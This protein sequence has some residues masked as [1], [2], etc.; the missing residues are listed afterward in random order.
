MGRLKKHPDFDPDRIMRELMD[1]VSGIYEETGKIQRTAEEI[2]VSHLKVRKILV[3]AGVFENE[4]A[5][6]ISSLY[7]S[8]KS[9]LEIQEITV[10]GRSAVNAYL[11]YV[12][13]PYNTSELSANAERIRVF[14][15]RKACV[16]R[17]Q[18]DMTEDAL[19]K[20][21]VV[22]QNYRFSTM[23]GLPFSYTL[24]VGRNGQLNKE[25]LVSRRKESKTLAWSS[26]RLAFDKAK[27][28]QGEVIKRP[29][30]IGDIRGISYIY[31]MFLRFGI[32][33]GD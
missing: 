6:E 13:V 32:I 29:K 1:V 2:G 33:A 15:E 16:D 14:R 18:T 9:P 10:L 26:M 21:V 8:G 20:A 28:M 12:K 23:R 27:E 11:P 4:V 7:Q 25:L 17:L 22:F 3:T 5:A 24:K 19:W 31:A 30:Q